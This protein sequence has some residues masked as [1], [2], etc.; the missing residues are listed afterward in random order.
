[1]FDWGIEEHLMYVYEFF[2]ENK[3][4]FIAKTVSYTS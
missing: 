1:M 3:Q 4:N 2:M